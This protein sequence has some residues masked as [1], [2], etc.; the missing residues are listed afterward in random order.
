MLRGL[1]RAVYRVADIEKA[2]QWY[3]RVL[4]KDPVLDLSGAV[5]FQ[6]GDSDLVLVPG[7]EQSSQAK[8][9][10]TAFWTVDDVD[11]AYQ[12]LLELGAVPHTP[13]EIA[14]K[15]KRASVLDPFGNILGI[16]GQ[17]PEA[18]KST[19]EQRASGTAMGVTF[20][21]ALGAMD[22]R[23]EI[24]GRDYLAEKFVSGEWLKALHDPVARKE[25]AGR[26]MTSGMYE[27]ILARTVFFDDLV[28]QALK[29]SI[30]QIVFLG[31]GYDTRPYR[32][33]DLIKTTR[34]FELD[35]HTTQQS[36]K[37]LLQKADIPIP[38]QL[39]F[40]GINF[41]IDRLSDA[42]E[43]AG[44]RKTQKALFIWEGVTYYLL[45]KVV[46]ETMDFIRSISLPGST[47][48]FDYGSRFPEMMEAYGFRALAEFMR[49]QVTGEPAGL[50]GIER[51]KIEEFLSKRGF[52]IIEHYSADDME[53]KYL[54]LRDGSL[55]GKVTG[56]F[57][58]A[59]ASVAG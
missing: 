44:F 15:I 11:V 16:I 58:F 33:R 53:R 38:E 10:V 27:Y 22:P 6:T 35:I 20:L 46:D 18:V 3:R 24:R 51:G 57:C 25:L 48:G 17:N 30:P 8:N 19:V 28:E 40:V 54:T 26:R 21:R 2:K 14:G 7:A 52:R 42:L 4:E 39:T 36:K 37:K 56:H 50:F 55:A 12:R 13:V 5:V 49:T 59:Y 31:A 23:E 32:F 1:K 29:E 45:P 34:I 9:N 47:I 43:N 41:K